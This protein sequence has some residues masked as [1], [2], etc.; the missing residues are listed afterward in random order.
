MT[1]KTKMDNIETGKGG[2]NVLLWQIRNLRTIEVS[3]A[4]F[5]TK[6][7][8]IFATG[9]SNRHTKAIAFVVFSSVM[10]LLLFFF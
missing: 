10:L 4:I 3:K 2:L 8:N 1:Y 9:C 6:C 5:G 7:L